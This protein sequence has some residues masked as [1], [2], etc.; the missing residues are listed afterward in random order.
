VEIYGIR[1]IMFV[2]KI[3]EHKLLPRVYYIPAL[4]NSIISLS[5]L[6]EGG[7]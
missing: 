1:S 4:W 6:D 3:G 2:G 5:Q 7:S